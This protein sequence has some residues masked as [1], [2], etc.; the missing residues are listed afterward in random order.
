[1]DTRSEV[2][3][4]TGPEVPEDTGPEVPEDTGPEVPEDTE[5]Q[6][7][8]GCVHPTSVPSAITYA[9]GAC[10]YIEFQISPKAVQEPQDSERPSGSQ[11]QPGSSSS[12][13]LR[14][15]RTL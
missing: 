7:P 14:P 1:M 4:D 12:T 3:E 10:Y 9:L 11:P 6:V 5:P 8:E 15:R 13:G 2:P